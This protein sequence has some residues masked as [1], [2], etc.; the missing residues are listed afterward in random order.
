MKFRRSS[1]K[2]VDVEAAIFVG[3]E[4]SWEGTAL[5]REL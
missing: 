2:A 5:I 1:S 3:V 4:G